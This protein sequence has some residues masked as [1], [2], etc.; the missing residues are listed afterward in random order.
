MLVNYILKYDNKDRNN[1]EGIDMYTSYHSDEDDKSQQTDSNF[2]QDK[3]I[4]EKIKKLDPLILNALKNM[5]SIHIEEIN[6]KIN[7]LTNAIADP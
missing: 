7:K 1:R 3:S 4:I 2:M 6:K 5:N